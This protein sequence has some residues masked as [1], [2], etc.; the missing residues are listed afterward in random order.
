MDK[1][2]SS[3]CPFDQIIKDVFVVGYGEDTYH[4]AFRAMEAW[5]K[6]HMGQD[7]KKFDK[8]EQLEYIQHLGQHLLMQVQDRVN[9]ELAA[10]LADRYEITRRDLTEFT[11]NQVIE[12]FIKGLL[13]PTRRS[14][15]PR[16]SADDILG[17]ALDEMLRQR[18][19]F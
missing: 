13:G 10:V 14:S 9:Q 3:K 8:D 18:F 4:A 16:R 2:I 17:G 1:D 11:E 19:R 12:A 15:R 7:F 5:I 6:E